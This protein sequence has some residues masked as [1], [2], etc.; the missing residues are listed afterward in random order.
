MAAQCQGYKNDGLRCMNKVKGE[1][2]AC[3][4]HHKSDPDWS[5]SRR[6]LRDRIMYIHSRVDVN[7]RTHNL[8]VPHLLVGMSL[9]ELVTLLEQAEAIVRVDYPGYTGAFASCTNHAF[10][11]FRIRTHWERAIERVPV[12]LRVRPDRKSVV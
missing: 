12:N 4:V 1:H 3:G 10:R 6:N 2:P 11:T 5:K 8:I 7:H 9:P